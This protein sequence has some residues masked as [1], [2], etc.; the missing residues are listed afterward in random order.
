[1][2]RRGPA[3]GY[4]LLDFGDGRRLEAWGSVR[5]VRPDPRALG[6]PR[7]SAGDWH[8]ADAIF[9]GRVGAGTWRRQRPFADP[10]PVS[11]AGLQF[12]IRCAPSM[13]TGLFPEQAAHWRWFEETARGP[14]LDVLNLFA[15]T[16]GASM[17]LARLGHR[18]THVDASRPVVN[19]A[20]RNAA[21]NGLATVRWIEED[22]RTFVR[23]E[24]RRGRQYGGVLLDPPVFGRSAGG[25]WRLETDL[26][27][28][29]DE[30][31]PLLLPGARFVLLNVY[32]IE[33][34][35]G[36]TAGRLADRLLASRHALALA[37]MDA[38]SL[39]LQ[40]PDGRCLPTGVYARTSSRLDA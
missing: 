13:H 40:T 8:A 24:R 26:D 28:L 21:G 14:A 20:R 30:V 16:G 15:Y 38:G 10:W 5:L 11:H 31:L 35:P 36:A 7:L 39:D 3:S 37:P 33:E 1:V 34:T 4:D 32:G 6:T 2:T 25:A 17:A 9:E 12:E 19:W 27:P 18:V 22:A 29:L 23:R